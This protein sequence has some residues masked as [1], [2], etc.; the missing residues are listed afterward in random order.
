VLFP[1]GAL[2]RPASLWG[3]NAADASS[4]QI[5]RVFMGVRF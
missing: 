1:F 2:D 4:A 5:L 3:A